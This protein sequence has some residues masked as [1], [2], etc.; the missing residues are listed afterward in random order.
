MRFKLKFRI[1]GSKNNKTKALFLE[2]VDYFDL[3]ITLSEDRW[4]ITNDPTLIKY[5]YE[6]FEAAVHCLNKYILTEGEFTIFNNFFNMLNS[7]ISGNKTYNSVIG[8]RFLESAVAKVVFGNSDEM[9]FGQRPHINNNT[10]ERINTIKYIFLKVLLNAIFFP[11]PEVSLADS[12]I[13]YYKQKTSMVDYDETYYFQIVSEV[14]QPLHIYRTGYDGL[15]I[16]PFFYFKILYKLALS[17]M[18]YMYE[19][20][21]KYIQLMNKEADKVISWLEENEISTA[22]N[23]PKN[24]FLYSMDYKNGAVFFTKTI[25]PS[26]KTDKAYKEE[27]TVLKKE[28][29]DKTLYEKS[30]HYLRNIGINNLIL[31]D[32]PTYFNSSI[33]DNYILSSVPGVSPIL[34]IFINLSRLTGPAYESIDRRIVFGHIY[35]QQRNHSHLVQIDWKLLKGKDHNGEKF[36]LMMDQ[37]MGYTV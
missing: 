7:Y 24:P 25:D 29:C 6:S 31:A 14:L 36:T 18:L 22:P 5:N 8:H 3:P 9:T 17:S 16:V 13:S 11:P 35:K 15:G 21:E 32:I 4:M 12:Y 19:P 2:C 28:G 23:I 26:I 34:N 37:M 33:K 20:D 10:E 30:L 1:I 27:Y